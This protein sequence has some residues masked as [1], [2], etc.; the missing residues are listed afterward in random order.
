MESKV[1]R[2]N[3]RINAPYGFFVKK[4]KIAFFN[5]DYLPLGIDREDDLDGKD[6]PEYDYQELFNFIIL[7][8]KLMNRY[9]SISEKVISRTDLEVFYF[10][11]DSH[12]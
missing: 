11:N 6:L 8:T 1:S 2:K 9:K 5:R 10:Y 7:P 4:N 12:I 3:R